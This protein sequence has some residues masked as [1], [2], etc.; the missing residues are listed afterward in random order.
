[1]NKKKESWI[2]APLKRLVDEAM[3]NV[4]KRIAKKFGSRRIYYNDID[5]HYFHGYPEEYM[6]LICEITHLEISSC[7]LSYL[8]HHNR[9]YAYRF[10]H[11]RYYMQGDFIPQYDLRGL[12]VLYTDKPPQMRGEMNE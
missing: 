1:M 8:V 11:I 10:R 12:F 6:R 5:F 2:S 3:K 7:D 4:R 9:D